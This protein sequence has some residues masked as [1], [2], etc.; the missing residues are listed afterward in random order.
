MT[1]DSL[2]IG[3]Q[4]DSKRFIVSFTSYLARIPFVSQVL[5][6]LYDQNLQADKILLWLA[7][8]QFPNK[9]SD[10]PDAL[11]ADAHAGKFVCAGV[12]IS[13][14]IKSISMICRNFRMTSL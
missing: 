2:T 5:E 11:V 9:E 8:E 14:V 6:G 13:G 10:L 3:T 1:S 7:K 12:M 4:K